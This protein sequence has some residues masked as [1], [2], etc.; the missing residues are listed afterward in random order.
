MLCNLNVYISEA[1]GKPDVYASDIEDQLTTPES[2][3]LLAAYRVARSV[4]GLPH[5]RMIDSIFMREL[6]RDLCLVER[7]RFGEFE[8]LYY[9]DA[10]KRLS[11]GDLTGKTTAHQ[12]PK[13]GAI[14]RR[15]FQQALT[16]GAPLYVIDREAENSRVHL[17]GRL[18]LPMVDANG[19]QVVAAYCRP[20]EY[21]HELLRDVLDAA[22]D[23]I[24]AVKAVRD[25]DGDVIDGAVLAVNAP[26]LEILRTD[27]DT[28]L[29]T[30]ISTLLPAAR[31]REMWRR[32]M[33]VLHSRQTQSFEYHHEAGGASRWYRI[34][35]APMGDGL[36]ISFT[37]ITELKELNLA[38]E[39][40]SRQLV[41]E[42][43]QRSHVEQELWN[44]AH[45]DPLTGV[46]NRR[47]MQERAIAT[48]KL[49]RRNG[50]SCAMIVI[51]IDFFK[52]I[53]DTFG[54][55][56]GDKAIMAVARIAR[57]S[58]RGERDVIARMGGEEFALLLYDA[59]VADGTASAER[60]RRDIEAMQ[61]EEGG[62]VFGVTISCG[63]SDSTETST[64]EDLL[65][66]ADQAL[67][68]AKRDGRNRTS[69]DNRQVQAA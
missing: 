32:H 59:S 16:L 66:D 20:R 14:A 1:H 69:G 58:C 61:I 9:G 11:G 62:R 53:N 47:S 6:G 65:A 44:L 64:Y 49:A 40:K 60:I 28:A 27:N 68:A 21:T 30:P 38:L 54:H 43:A 52:R 57:S 36:V 7:N 2:R 45:L 67:Y 22:A 33:D 56:A 23:G 5:V 15:N 42:I 12:P 34:V 8:Y 26:M 3:R 39:Q 51:D 18:L 4:E 46:S 24:L 29:G 41:E 35:S 37:D 48:L 63:V 19:G 55:A 25:A 10:L 17:W 31:D 13:A 50:V